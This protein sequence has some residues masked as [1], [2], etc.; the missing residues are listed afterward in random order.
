MPKFG[1][2]N[3]RFVAKPP[4]DQHGGGTAR[5]D[6]GIDGVEGVHNISYP[7]QPGSSGCFHC[8]KGL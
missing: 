1:S 3:A 7:C 4:Q 5:R 6:G 2:R 8:E